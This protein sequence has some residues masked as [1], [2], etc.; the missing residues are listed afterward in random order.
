MPLVVFC[1]KGSPAIPGTISCADKPFPVVA[2]LINWSRFYLG[3]DSDVSWLAATGNIPMGLFADR[4]TENPVRIGIRECLLNEKSDIQQWDIYT[5][6][7]TV[8]EHIQ[9]RLS[10]EAPAGD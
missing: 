3:P 2:A 10:L 8:V 5:R 9:S 1:T 6:L 4:L 7:E